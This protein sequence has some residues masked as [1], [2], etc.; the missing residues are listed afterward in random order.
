MIVSEFPT[1]SLM[2]LIGRVIE[3]CPTLEGRYRLASVPLSNCD[4]LRGIADEMA[5]G[6]RI[7]PVTGP[8]CD[9]GL[10]GTRFLA[11]TGLLIPSG[12]QLVRELRVRRPDHQLAIPGV[13]FS[14]QVGGSSLQSS[15][16]AA[17]VLDCVE[18]VTRL[19]T[20]WSPPP[21][22]VVPHVSE[23]VAKIVLSYRRGAGHAGV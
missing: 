19:G 20:S 4:L 1:Q 22:Y 13:S 16:D 14:A 11:A 12:D 5:L 3:R 2:N 6:I 9:R 23:A 21:E 15:A 10:D 8:S 18:V 7:E 17:R